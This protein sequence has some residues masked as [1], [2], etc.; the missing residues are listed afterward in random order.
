MTPNNNENYLPILGDI[1]ENISNKEKP[2]KA[3]A[4]RNMRSR[5]S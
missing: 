5:F 3:V 2:E 1:P 4:I